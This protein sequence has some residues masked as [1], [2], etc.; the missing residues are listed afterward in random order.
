MLRAEGTGWQR[1]QGSGFEEQQAGLRAWSVESTGDRR[2]DPG[3]GVLNALSC[4]NSLTPH[5]V[6]EDHTRVTLKPAGDELSREG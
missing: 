6:P 5:L 4:I 2:E 3:S 1:R